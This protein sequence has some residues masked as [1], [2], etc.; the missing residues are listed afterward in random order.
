MAEEEIGN[1]K[2]KSNRLK[3]E[4]VYY[5]NC[6]ALGPNTRVIRVVLANKEGDIIYDTQH[7]C[8][9]CSYAADEFKPNNGEYTVEKEAA[10][11]G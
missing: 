4:L 11:N 7:R 8:P 5:H 10:R 9:F 3:T 1:T 2:K 6:A